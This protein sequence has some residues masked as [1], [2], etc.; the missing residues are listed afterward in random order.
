[1]PPPTA[2]GYSGKTLA[3]K[4]GLSAGA[5]AAAINAPPHYAELLGDVPAPGRLGRGKYVFIHLFA[6]DR[7]GLERN[8]A[9]AVAHLAPGGALWISWPKKS[10]PLFKNLS[11]NAIRDIVLPLG[12]VDVKVCAV[13]AD[14]SGLKFMWRKTGPLPSRAR[15][16]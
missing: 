12:I 9:T 6:A 8:I 14:W 7:A 4:L 16:A 15:S 10:S 13:D 5:S 3:A 11:E 2:A 1:M